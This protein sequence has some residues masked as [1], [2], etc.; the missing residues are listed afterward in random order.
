MN[1]NQKNIETCLPEDILAEVASVPTD[2]QF[3]S[4]VNESLDPLRQQAAD[5]TGWDAY[6]QIGRAHV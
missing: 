5:Q 1:E 2:A 4:L 3:V 6:E